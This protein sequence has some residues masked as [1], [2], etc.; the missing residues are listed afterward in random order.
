MTS[1]DNKIRIGPD[2]PAWLQI[3]RDEIDVAEMPGPRA[4][5]RI[6]EYLQTCS[7]LL[8][9]DQKT[10]ETPWCSAFV[11]FCVTK[12]GLHGTNHALA[13]SWKGHGVGLESPRMGC[14][15]LVRRSGGSGFHVAFYVGETENFII[16]LGGNQHDSV[17][18]VPWK[19]VGPDGKSNIICYRWPGAADVSLPLV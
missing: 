19:K 7:N 12:V 16:L 9:A 14:I 8:P 11:N 1:G 5:A 10:D 15:A 3:A 13:V 18:V 4:H 6:K 2:A 17:S